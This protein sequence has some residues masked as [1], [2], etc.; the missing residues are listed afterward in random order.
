MYHFHAI[1]AEGAAEES[2]RTGNECKERAS[3]LQEQVKELQQQLEEERSKMVCAVH[4]SAWCAYTHADA[5]VLGLSG[6]AGG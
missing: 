1:L 6:A 3:A 4:D 2:R 5:G